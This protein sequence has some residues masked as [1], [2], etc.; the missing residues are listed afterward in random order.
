MYESF[1]GLTGKPFHLSPDPRFFFESTGHAR[2]LA[3]LHYGVEQGE[4]FVIV[5]GDIGTGKTT[6]AQLLFA[7]LERSKE[8]V[9]IHLVAGQDSA[10]DL[11]FMIANAFGLKAE[12]RPRPALLKDV[13]GFLREQHKRGRRV[14]LLVDEVQN[15]PLTALVMLR[16]L[17]NFQAGEQCLLQSVLLGQAEFRDTLLQPN[18]RPLRQRVIAACHLTPLETSKETQAYIEH[19]LHHVGWTDDP[20]I[21]AEAFTDIHAFTQGVPRR[22]NTFCDRLLLFAFLEELHTIN[23][24]TVKAVAAEM[25]DDLTFDA[26]N[27]TPVAVASVAGGDRR[28]KAD[29]IWDLEA[30]VRQL[31][32]ALKRVR[33]GIQQ[34]MESDVERMGQQ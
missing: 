13:E 25:A 26:D 11:L 16:M 9:A 1:Y 4:G 5:T 32:D 15:L 20:A 28:P 14:M 17:S 29:R 23:P 27:P 22:I 30:R 33:D 6:L 19:R 18:L 2:A 21:Q 31:E 24:A 10:D 8:I 34:S 12:G 3:Y 7:E